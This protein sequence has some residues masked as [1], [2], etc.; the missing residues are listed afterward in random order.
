[1]SDETEGWYSIGGK[2]IRKYYGNMQFT[3]SEENGE[4][5]L[6]VGGSWLCCATRPTLR[7]CQIL[8]HA[9]ARLWSG[10]DE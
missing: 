5:S 3:I 7:E 4:I 1:M 2:C 9:T 8:A 6:Y 10:S